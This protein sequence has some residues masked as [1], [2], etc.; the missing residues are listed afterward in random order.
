MKKK[1]IN[2]C[3]KCGMVTCEKEYCINCKISDRNIIGFV[4]LTCKFP[5]MVRST[6]RKLNKNKSSK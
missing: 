6:I 4:G 5:D 2:T 1:E 3:K